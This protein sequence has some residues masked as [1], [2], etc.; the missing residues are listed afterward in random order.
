M[1]LFRGFTLFTTTR[2]RWPGQHQVAAVPSQRA[3][4]TA[5]NLRVSGFRPR[6]ELPLELVS[7][8]AHSNSDSARSAPEKTARVSGVCCPFPTWPCL[9]LSLWLVWK[10]PSVAPVGRQP[11]PQE[12]SRTAPSPWLQPSVP[13]A[14]AV[15]PPWRSSRPGRVCHPQ[16]LCSFA[17][18]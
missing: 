8:W 15:C 4:E 11:W 6:R 13:L 2:S 1:T 9:S 16:L 18:V 12:S 14:A 3:N 10:S 7:R 5:L 17:E